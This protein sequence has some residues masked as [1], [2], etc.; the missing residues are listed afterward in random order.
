MEFMYQHSKKQP[1][2]Q[3]LGFTSSML[4]NCS[5]KYHPKCWPLMVR[6]TTVKSVKHHLKQIQDDEVSSCWLKFCHVWIGDDG[7]MPMQ[8]EYQADY[9]PIC[10]EWDWNI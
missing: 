6:N 10:A 9:Y 3:T 7:D 8:V 2:L 5:V 4:G 1:Q